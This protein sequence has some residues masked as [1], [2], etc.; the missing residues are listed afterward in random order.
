MVLPIVFASILNGAFTTKIGYYTP[1][2][3]F[4]TCLSII[5]AGLLTTLEIDASEGKWIGYQIIYGFGLGCASQAP[6]L[7]AQTVL[8]RED[9]GIGASLMF[10]G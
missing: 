7:A 6:N 8:P 2:L 9:V 10:F 1:S 5:G 4:G 3:I